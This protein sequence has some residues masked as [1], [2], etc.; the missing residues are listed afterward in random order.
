VEGIVAVMRH[1]ADERHGWRLRA[2]I[3]MLW[4]GGLR[5]QRRSHSPS[6]TSTSGADQCSFATEREGGDA[7]SAWTSG[8]GSTSGLG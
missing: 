7:K 5:V 8:A 4:R 2:M 1:A 3:V 6:T